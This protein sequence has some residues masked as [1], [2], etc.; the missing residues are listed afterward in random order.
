M[1][2]RLRAKH[3]K[4]K[5]NG[6][7]KTQISD[8]IKVTKALTFAQKIKWHWAGLVP[9]ISDRRWTTTIT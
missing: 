7:K 1:S 2:K 6:Q 3:V 4:L 5:E 9:R 8:I